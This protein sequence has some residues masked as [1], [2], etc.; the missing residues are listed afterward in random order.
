VKSDNFSYFQTRYEASEF[1]AGALRRHGYAHLRSNEQRHLNNGSCSNLLITQR[2]VT[3]AYQR[4]Q[5]RID[6]SAAFLQTHIHHL[7]IMA[8]YLMQYEL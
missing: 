4:R 2:F 3:I 1:A 5:Q 7:N 8:K 6:S